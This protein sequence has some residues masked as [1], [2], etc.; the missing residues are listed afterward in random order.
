VILTAVIGE[1]YWITWKFELS[2]IVERHW[3]S[4][5]RCGSDVLAATADSLFIRVLKAFI[6]YC[7]CNPL[8]FTHHGCKPFCRLLGYYYLR[9]RRLY[10]HFGLFVCLSVGKLK[11]LWTDFDEISCR[12][13]AWP[14]EGPMSQFWWRS[15]S[16]SGSRSPMSEIR[17]HLI[18]E[19]PTDF[20]ESLWRAGVWPRDRL[21]TFW[22]RSASLSGSGSPFRITILIREELA[23]FYYA[24]VRRRSVLAEYF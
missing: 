17:I 11:K 3:T 6:I 9:R 22:W 15:G 7:L 1:I 23:Q 16:P 5:F 21:F 24:G 10:F 19:L 20:V 2:T 18:I 14:R 4:L 12:G 13:R 8:Y